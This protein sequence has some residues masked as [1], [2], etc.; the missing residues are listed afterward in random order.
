[1]ILTSKWT[2][3]SI[4]LVSRKDL[5]SDALAVKMLGQVDVSLD[6]AAER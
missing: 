4:V 2:R 1:M 5:D 6:N 3:S